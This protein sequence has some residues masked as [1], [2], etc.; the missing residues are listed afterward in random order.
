MEMPAMKTCE[1]ECSWCSHLIRYDQRKK[2]ELEDGS[3]E[4]I[5]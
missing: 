4:I 2:H 3:V 5:L 1:K